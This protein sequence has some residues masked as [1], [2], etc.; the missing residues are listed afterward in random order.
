MCV[1]AEYIY[2][3]ITVWFSTLYGSQIEIYLHFNVSVKYVLVL[4]K[5]FI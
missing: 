3:Y 1:Y 5:M 4:I 2:I